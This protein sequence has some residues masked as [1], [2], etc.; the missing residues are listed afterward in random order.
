[1][2]VGVKSRWPLIIGQF[3]KGDIMSEYSKN[4]GIIQQGGEIDAN[5]LAV[6]RGAAATN[7]IT[8]TREA[9]EQKGLKEIS[10]KL[11]ELIRLIS[12]HSKSLDHS[13]AVLG[14][15]RVVAEELSRDKP[16]KFAIMAI[17]DGIAN[18]VKSVASIVSSVETLKGSVEALL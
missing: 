9:L 7:I 6:G 18:G 13:E 10:D 17:L 12:E 4:E 11:N 8:T 2:E 15:T 14:S 3:E 1:V 16:N 5:Q